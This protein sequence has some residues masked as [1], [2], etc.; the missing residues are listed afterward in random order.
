[1]LALP[2]LI[3]LS[4]IAILGGAGVGILLTDRG[5]GIAALKGL[6]ASFLGG[7]LI[8]HLLPE[9]Y[10]KI[11]AWSLLFIFAGFLFML[12]IEMLHIRGDHGGGRF[13]T[14]EVLWA[15]LII[16]QITDGIGLAVASESMAGDLRMALAVIAHRIP[17]AAVVIWLFGKRNQ[18]AQAW[19][20]IAGMILATVVGALFARNLAPWLSS[21]VVDIF[22]AFIAG[23]FLHLLTHDFLDHHAH[24]P[25]D[26]R[27]EFLA[28]LA[29]IGL[30]VLAER[31]LPGG[32]AHG[33]ETTEHGPTAGDFLHSML[34]LVRETAPYLLLGL[35][36]SG[37]L[38]AYMP[39]SPISWLKKG[40]PLRQSAKGMIFGLPLPICSCGVL[41]LF[42]GLARKGVPAACLVAFL[43]ATPELGI[44]SFLL[45]IKLL[46][47][48]FTSVRLIVAMVLPMAIALI[49]VRF[50]GRHP[51]G[52]RATAENCCGDAEKG[53]EETKSWWRFAFVDLVDDIFPFVFFG[54]CIAAFAET[55][56]PTSSFTEFV[57]QWDILLLAALGIPFYVCASASVPF[58]LI[59]LHHGF[60]VGAVVVFLF[61]GPATNVATVLTVNKAFGN[62]SGLKLAVISFFTA[63]LMGFLVN[64]LYTPGE[65]DVFQ[66]RDHG[67][68]LIDYFSIAGIGLLGLTSL[69]R[70]GPLHWISTVVGM[71]PGIIHHPP[72]EAEH[73][74]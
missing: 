32:I 33:A 72:A 65:L 73:A 58:A 2:Q 39:A 56:W 50:L 13:F 64:G 57:G 25:L 7:L 30:L 74:N 63:I 17:V 55:L 68:T 45:S 16:H 29:G 21:G 46:G 34:V 43:I 54:L 47:W 24:D 67:W 1:M 9:A 40:G 6:M 52:D 42:L 70:F 22:Y 51:V 26:R 38:H 8:L 15:G 5:W 18:K 3:L 14:A 59:L 27:G 12:L 61:A 53:R 31:F 62:R 44:D 10:H 23:S 4:I 20:R 11:G 41:P 66:I 19:W 71:I 48:K 28:F 60:S 36:I 49:A 35:V 69:Y 37:L